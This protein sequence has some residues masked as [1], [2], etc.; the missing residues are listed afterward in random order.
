MIRLIVVDIIE[1]PS[2]EE[3]EEEED[4]EEEEMDC[5]VLFT[6]SSSWLYVSSSSS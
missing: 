5:K 6:I 1:K 3:E 4:E 2:L